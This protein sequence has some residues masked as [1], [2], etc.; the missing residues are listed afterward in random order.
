[1]Q[2][3][4]PRNGLE[5]LLAFFLAGTANGGAAMRFFRSFIPSEVEEEEEALAETAKYPFFIFS[6]SFFRA[7]CNYMVTRKI[8]HDDEAPKE[9]GSILR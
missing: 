9:K 6:F 8:N 5:E 2:K 1:M 3:T 4:M 7:N